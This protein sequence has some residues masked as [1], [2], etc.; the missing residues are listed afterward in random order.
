MNTEV[1]QERRAK[2]RN[3]VEEQETS[4]LTQS[5]F[6]KERNL[7]LS[8]FVYY[9]GLIKAKESASVV[10]TDSFTPIQVNKSESNIASEIRIVLPNGFQCFVS[11]RI[12]VLQ[13]KRLVEV[14]LIC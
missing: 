6:C 5:V 14:L 1:H 2:W 11:S 13:I 10:S 9:R 8:Q 7:V 3:L 12:D 4:G